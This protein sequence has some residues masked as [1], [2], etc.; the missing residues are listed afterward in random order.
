[1]INRQLSDAI[2]IDANVDKVTNGAA[3]GTGAT[4]S[5]TATTTTGGAKHHSLNAS[6]NNM[7]MLV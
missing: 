2:Y 1:M 4:K 7:M 6:H 3:A 5:P